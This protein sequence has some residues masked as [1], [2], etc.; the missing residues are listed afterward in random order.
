M[1]TEISGS[2]TPDLS[3]SDDRPAPDITALSEV[4]QIFNHTSLSG[5]FFLLNAVPDVRLLF[6]GPSCGYD[7]A[8]LV[9]GTRAHTR[10]G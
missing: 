8:F 2:G 5:V 6:D 9:S 1:T 10:P 3:P 7:K 4:H